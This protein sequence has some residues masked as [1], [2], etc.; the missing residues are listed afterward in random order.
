MAKRA[1]ANMGRAVA[2]I[3][4]CLCFPSSPLPDLRVTIDGIDLQ[5]KIDCLF[6]WLSVVFSLPSGLQMLAIMPPSTR[7]TLP[8]MK[9]ARVLARNATVSPYSSGLP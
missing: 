8:V 3:V 1:S 2:L 6:R 5:D 9:D 7:M 4:L